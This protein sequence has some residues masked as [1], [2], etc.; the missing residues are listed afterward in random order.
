MTCAIAVMAKAPRAGKVKTRLSP[1]LSPEE[2]M[3]MSA[4]FLRDITENIRLA[5]QQADIAGFVAYAPAGLEGLFDGLLAE[6]TG[7]V[8]ADG[9][10][11]DGLG[12]MPP[13]VQGFGRS[14]LHATRSLLARGFASVCVLNSDSPTLPTNRLVRAARA[15]EQSGDRAVL[16]AAED[17]GYYLLGLKAAHAGCYADIAWST[18]AVAGQTRD[19]VRRLGLPLDELEPWY[20]VDDREALGRLLRDLEPGRRDQPYACPATAACVDRLGLRA[21]LA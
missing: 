21:R 6:G 17:G 18:D 1:P 2:A 12:D 13:G 3:A 11:G 8:L 14:L 19:A 5:A 15:L 16:G 20:D 7:L 9:Q 10:L 4:A